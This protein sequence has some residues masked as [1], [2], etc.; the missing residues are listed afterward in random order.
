MLLLSFFIVIC[1]SLNVLFYN[2]LQLEEGP[3]LLRSFR[4]KNQ[5]F[6]GIHNIS[7]I[8]QTN[9]DEAAPAFQKQHQANATGLS[10]CLLVND[11][12]PRLRE[13]LAYHYQILPLRS[14]II[15]VDPSSRTSP[16]E[17]L[18]QWTNPIAVA[19][20]K[21]TTANNNHN[22]IMEAI[23]ID[24]WEEDEFL[25]LDQP[26][27]PCQASDPEKGCEWTHRNRQGYFIMK[28]MAEL[29]QRGKTWVLLTDVDEYITFN[30]IRE[31]DTA[32]V[33]LAND[34]DVSMDKSRSS[35]QLKNDE[36]VNDAPP[37]VPTL[38]DNHVIGTTQLLAAIHNDTYNG[39]ND[40][41][42]VLINIGMNE[43]QKIKNIMY[44]T[45]E[46]QTMKLHGGH[47]ITDTDGRMYYL[48]REELHLPQHLSVKEALAMR[49]RLPSVGQGVTILDVL[50]SD[51]V[52]EI[53][54]AETKD[55]G[56]CL[57]MPRLLYGSREENPRQSPHNPIWTNDDIKVPEGFDANDFVTL[58]YRWHADK[59]N[60]STNKFQKTI[61]D[62]SRIPME[63]LVGTKAHNI[64][65]PLE[66]YCWADPP[67]YSTSLFRV[68]SAICF[69]ILYP[70]IVCMCHM[71]LK[72][73]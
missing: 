20:A 28:C 64:H 2:T 37:G 1:L 60:F 16:K 11:E 66:T 65:Q 52:E 10:A 24:I 50:S 4:N 58:R 12:N 48:E 32:V 26:R 18:S 40:G 45:K 30:N 8:I 47:L 62:V 61:I 23:E 6:R 15:A 70:S 72:Y 36:V 46:D 39:Q 29:K 49:A 51:E 5:S 3:P 21:N 69:I 19:S 43:T 67:N 57:S 44:E 56:P 31:D 68:V 59:E 41:D 34:A 71:P 27:G 7:N 17:I 22:I 55:L 13:W 38:K 9:N 33:D 54:E 53:F 42:W 63:E 35:Q 25:P 73:C 14:L